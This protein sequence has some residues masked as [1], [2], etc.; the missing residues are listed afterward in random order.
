MSESQTHDGE[1]LSRDKQYERWKQDQ[2][3]Q[4]SRVARDNPFPTFSGPEMEAKLNEMTQQARE[5]DEKIW[6]EAIQKRS[7]QIGQ[8]L[9]ERLEQEGET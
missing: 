1:P 7:A 4:A 6:K 8:Q 2:R 3:E 9:N 5:E